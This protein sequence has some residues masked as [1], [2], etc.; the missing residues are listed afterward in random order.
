MN[1]VDPSGL[2]YSHLDSQHVKPIDPN[3]AKEIDIVVN[4]RRCYACD[5]PNSFLDR[6]P[7]MTFGDHA[8][9]NPNETTTVAEDERDIVVN[10]PTDDR[11]SETSEED[12]VVQAPIPQLASQRGGNNQSSEEFRHLSNE[13]I[14][15]KRK[16]AT[17][18][19]RRKLQKEEKARGIR[20]K[21]KVRGGGI[22]RAPFLFLAPGFEEIWQSM[23]CTI[24]PTADNC[25][26]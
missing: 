1:L 10:A 26:A 16:K 21:P 24:N 13:E 2:A 6:N 4:G 5:A 14:V 23:Q 17:G 12:I 8:Q 15:E 9:S 7:G 19:E 3:S 11:D 18:E 25:I 22:I 20:N